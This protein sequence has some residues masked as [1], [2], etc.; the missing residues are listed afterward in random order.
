MNELKTKKIHCPY[1]REKI[2]VALDCSIEHQ[3]YIEDCQVCC[4]PITFNVSIGPDSEITVAVSH[5]NE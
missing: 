4:R 5:E 1:C 3:Q 2:S